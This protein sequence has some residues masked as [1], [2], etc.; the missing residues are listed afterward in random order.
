MKQYTSYALV[1][2]LL[3]F[4]SACR[5]PGIKPVHI[6]DDG[7]VAYDAQIRMKVKK[8]LSVEFTHSS[9]IA[10]DSIIIDGPVGEGDDVRNTRFRFGENSIEG[11]GTLSS[12]FNTKEAGVNLVFHAVEKE[13][14]KLSIL[15]GLIYSSSSLEFASNENEVDLEFKK[16][17]LGARTGVELEYS[18][19][20]RVSLVATAQKRRFRGAI[21]GSQLDLFVRVE[22]LKGLSLDLGFHRNKLSFSVGQD[23]ALQTEV[24]DDC[25]FLCTSEYY[26]E[27]GNSKV[28]VVS[29]GPKMGI[30]Y[31]F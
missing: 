31:E 4:V 24:S 19:L 5:S 26:Y 8:Q 14:L 11:P 1:L 7:V 25:I 21:K 17:L 18:V 3:T 10:K 13:K 20:P 15:G 9:R 12:L 6:R 28:D 27:S 2:L 30:T 23:I 22:A 16:S 29:Q